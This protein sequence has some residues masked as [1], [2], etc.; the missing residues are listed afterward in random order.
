[1]RYLRTTDCKLA[2]LQS[3]LRASCQQTPRFGEFE[4]SRRNDPGD[5][6]GE[7]W[8]AA[9]SYQMETCHL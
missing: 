4:T 3:Y 7:S 1:M 8:L 2:D 6:A 5:R 9:G